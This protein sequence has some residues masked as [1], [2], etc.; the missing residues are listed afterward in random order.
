[1]RSDR[2]P[3]HLQ[4]HLGYWLRLVSNAVSQ[5]FARKVEAKGVTVAE[6]VVLRALYD[7]ERIKPSLLAERIGVTKG[8]VSKLADRLI[9][10]DLV[11]RDANADDKRAH[12]LCLKASGRA[13]VPKLAALA[14]QNDEL[15]FG[16]L[17]SGERGELERLLRKI[18]SARELKNVPTD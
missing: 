6:W 4:A 3:S 11:V 17:A 18:V 10:K 5:S 7:V 14:D 2:Q 1:M 15:F 8:A 13:L 16:V 9:Q 12:A